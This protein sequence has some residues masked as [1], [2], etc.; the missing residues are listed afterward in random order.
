MRKSKL[1]SGILFLLTTA[2]VHAQFATNWVAFN[3]HNLNGLPGPT[4]APNVTL[5][6]LGGLTTGGGPIGQLTNFL[7]G[8]QLAA[9]LTVSWTG[10]DG[11]D[12]FGA[13]ADPDVDSPADLLFKGIVDIGGAGVG[14]DEGIIGLRSSEMNAVSI[15]FSN[16]DVSQ[17][18]VFRGTSVRGGSGANLYPDRWAV[19]TIQAA[20]WV[21][22]HVDASANLNIFTQDTYPA[23]GLTEG[24]VA[25][26]S[27]YNLPGSLVGWN[28]I[29][30]N[31]DGT[32]TIQETQFIGIAPFGT[33]SAG[34]YGYGMNAI[35]IAEIFS[36]PPT[37]PIILTQPAGVTNSEG[38]IVV[39][40]VVATGTPPLT[41]QWY[42][43]TPPGGSPISGATRSTF[44]VTNICRQRQGVVRA[45]RQRRLLRYGHGRTGPA[46]HQH[47]GSRS[48]EPRH[49]SPGL[50][51]C[52]LLGHQPQFDH[53]H[54]YRTA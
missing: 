42:K 30:P 7:N 23:G 4:T 32:I 18:Y 37:A 51:L 44:A 34:P 28:D 43:G 17:R 19:Y 6:H 48:R 12:D 49:H 24:Q 36:G 20:S 29:V 50:S 2:A 35:M 13:S 27:G 45:R 10:G 8:Q 15:T 16:L 21:D 38:Q 14:V 3:D 52:N 26:N 31:S 25:L 9:T 46:G 1:P 47:V 5:Y 39:L 53:P 11:P 41:Y 40:R 54:A 22:A 33:P